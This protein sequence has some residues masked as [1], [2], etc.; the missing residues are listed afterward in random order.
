MPAV[1]DASLALHGGP[2]ACPLG[3]PS[4]PLPDDDVRAALEQAYALGSWGTYHGPHGDALIADLQALVP[5]PQVTLS[6]SGT[7]AVELA[8][9]GVQVGPGDEVVLAAY[10]FP[11]N[12]RAIEAVGARPVLVDL[13]PG[14]WRLDAH[15]VVAALNDTTRAVLASHLHGDLAPLGAIRERCQPRGVAVIED[16][17]QSPGVVL[18]DSRHGIAGDVQVWS[19]GGSKLLTAGRGGAVF[20]SSPLVH[21][22]MHI[23]AHRG[24]DAFP[25]SQLQAAV[26]RPQLAKLAARNAVRRANVRELLHLLEPI[27]GELLQPVAL[28]SDGSEACYY[29]LAFLLT[30][31]LADRRDEFIAAVQAEGI[32][33]D[34]GFRGFTHRTAARCRR[35]GPL[36]HARRAAEQT[37]LLHHPVLLA[38]AETI[39]Q[40]AAGLR[41]VAQS[42]AR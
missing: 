24:N 20:T 33:L 19:F 42:L 15:Q 18:A 38:P 40:V 27:I 29:K 8:L 1:P 39:A 16:A 17:C 25:L 31:P 12:F 6:C 11:G 22:R 21:Q 34:A 7:L 3:P 10:D 36:D 41:K 5:A 13:E 26:L 14:T 30:G 37:V 9:R 23:F 2:P 35:V 32:A 28:P 4:W